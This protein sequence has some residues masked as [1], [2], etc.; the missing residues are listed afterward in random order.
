[1][2]IVKNSMD[3][4]RNV[5]SAEISSLIASLTTGR[6]EYIEL[7]GYYPGA[8][9]DKPVV[10]YLSETTAQD[11]GFSIINL[12]NNN[13]YKLELS[14]GD[15]ISLT[16]CGIRGNGTNDETVAINKALARLYNMKVKN[17]TITGINRIDVDNG[18]KIQLQSYTNY[19]LDGI[20]EAMPGRTNGYDLISF[21]QTVNTKLTGGKVKGN[22]Y[23][24]KAPDGSYYKMW[25]AYQS[26]QVGEYVYVN[27]CPLKVISA[28][29][30]GGEKPVAPLYIKCESITPKLVPSNCNPGYNENTQVTVLDG[31]VTYEV[32]HNTDLGEWGFGISVLNAENFHIQNVEIS[33][34]WG[35]GI[36][37]NNA[38]NGNI[39]N[40][41]CLDNRRQGASIIRGDGIN[42]L[43]SQFNNTVGTTPESGIDIEPNSENHVRNV[44]IVNCTCDRNEGYGILITTPDSLS[45]I[46]DVNI[47]NLTTRNNIRDGLACK[48]E[49]DSYSHTIFN[50]NIHN[51]ASS[52]NHASQILIEGTNGVK[53]RNGRIENAFDYPLVDLYKVHNVKINDLEMVGSGD[54]VR[55]RKAGD[56]ITLEGNYIESLKTC[57]IDDHTDSKK[58]NVTLRGNTLKSVQQS[59]VD[60]LGHS[61]LTIENNSILR[62]GTNGIKIG[63]VMRTAVTANKTTNIGL[64]DNNTEYGHI[65]IEGE[66][67]EVICENNILANYPGLVTLP[68]GIIAESSQM[69]Y[70]TFRTLHSHNN[71]NFGPDQI[72][73][74]PTVTIQDIR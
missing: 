44:N 42:I 59:A 52:G 63:N 62:S 55:I 7:M 53:I 41:K 69:N 21:A 36:Y 20:V 25:R 64:A 30:S 26:Y 40:V 9:Y 24:F 32:V 46:R 57:I 43:N 48:T 27:N 66:A 31:S 11:D 16:Y 35:D 2:A 65:V 1:M 14:F 6:P 22:K 72:I 71:S 10:Y 51:L 17:V 18:T 29:T 60:L 15:S 33:E 68:V 54:G 12:V 4:L 37:V 45:S 34:C 67:S 49:G 23:S 47:L 56:N 5:S 73:P 39:V 70:C 13:Q 28:G 8:P 58:E 3:E 50:I 19:T 74:N 38:Y 61:F